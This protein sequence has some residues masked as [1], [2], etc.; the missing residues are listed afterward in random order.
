MPLNA[1]RE[2]RKA[3]S[4]TTPTVILPT[5]RH[6]IRSSLVTAVLEH[7]VDLRAVG[8]H[9]R[10]GRICHGAVRAGRK[11][12]RCEE[13]DSG[14]YWLLQARMRLGG[15]GRIEIELPTP[16]FSGAPGCPNRANT[17][18]LGEIAVVKS[19]HRGMIWHDLARMVHGMNH[20]CSRVGGMNHG[21]AQ[22]TGRRPV[23]ELRARVWSGGVCCGGNLEAQTGR[24]ADRS[25]GELEAVVHR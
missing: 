8:L 24:A 6:P 21:V 11:R 10:V 14:T 17:R 22:G 3:R 2:V 9:R 13:P 18:E 1:V 16:R 7:C 5:V 15:K 19:V 12:K 23:D 20:L 4:A 25:R